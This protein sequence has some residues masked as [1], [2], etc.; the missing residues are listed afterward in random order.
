VVLIDP[1]SDAAHT[2]CGD[3]PGPR[4]GGDRATPG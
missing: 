3:A 4:N 1:E 2:T